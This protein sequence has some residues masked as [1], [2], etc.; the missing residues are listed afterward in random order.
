LTTGPLQVSYPTPSPVGQRIFFFGFLDRGELVRYDRKTDRW[1]P[2]LSGLAAT[3][4]DYSR[5][6]KWLAYAG[7]PEGSLWR[8]ALDGSQRLQLTAPPLHAV[9]PRWS[10]DGTQ[11]AFAGALPGKPSR[12]YVVPAGGGAVEQL[13]SGE[14]GPSGDT[15]PGWS[16]DG[17]SLVFADDISYTDQPD[18]VVLRIVNV[19][20]H[21]VSTL[22]GSQGLWSPRWS[23]DGRYIAALAVLKHKVMLYNVE[24]HGQTELAGLSAGW[25]AWSPDSQ[26]VYFA[27]QSEGGAATEWYRVRIKDRKLEPFASLRS[28]N[29]AVSGSSWIGMTPDG[30]LIST[31]DAGTNEIY[32]LDWE[33]P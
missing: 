28:L 21:G 24:T 7:Y 17:A 23:P 1:M 4:I 5:D 31:R 13:T 10:A 8:S 33:A 14:G 2:Y 29:A 18:K 11:I 12:V 30:S 6:G 27:Y 26:S 3:E 22:P 9:N 20:T 32:A 19:K 25:P 15:D 16:P